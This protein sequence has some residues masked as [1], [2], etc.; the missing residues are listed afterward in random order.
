[1]I[2]TDMKGARQRE[3]EVSLK[4]LNISGIMDIAQI[5]KEMG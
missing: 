2:A 4:F 1:M 3:V 5:L